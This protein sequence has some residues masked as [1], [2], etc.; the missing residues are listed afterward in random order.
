MCTFKA[1]SQ[2]FS[3]QIS[4]Q[5][6][7][8]DPSAL[9]CKWLFSDPFLEAGA[10]GGGVGEGRKSPAFPG[11]LRERSLAGTLVT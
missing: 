11:S 3:Y 8:I 4:A 7:P 1:A 6:F 2:P 9:K 10:R 5:I